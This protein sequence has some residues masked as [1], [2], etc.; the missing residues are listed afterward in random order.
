MLFSRYSVLVVLSI[1]ILRS[2]PFSNFRWDKKWPLSARLF[3]GQVNFWFIMSATKLLPIGVLTVIFNLK[4][5][6]F[7]I[8]GR[9]LFKESISK[10]EVIGMVLSFSALILMTYGA[11]NTEEID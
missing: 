6:W 4:P 9:A 7:A 2:N 8:L 5:F 11:K 3:S 1:V 10:V